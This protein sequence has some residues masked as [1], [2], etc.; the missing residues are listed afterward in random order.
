MDTDN[1]YN[2]EEFVSLK[3]KW[4]WDELNLIRHDMKVPI[5]E[6]PIR[7]AFINSNLF[8]L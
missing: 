7:H 8:L 2:A 1:I 6:E 5:G 3:A 4:L